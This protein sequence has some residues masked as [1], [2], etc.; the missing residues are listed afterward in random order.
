MGCRRRGSGGSLEAVDAVTAIGLTCLSVL[1]PFYSPSNLPILALA[2]ILPTA[3]V[4]VDKTLRL[5]H[6]GLTRRKV[7]LGQGLRRAKPRPP[8]AS[9]SGVSYRLPP[10]LCLINTSFPMLPPHCSL[11]LQSNFHLSSHFQ[12]PT[13]THSNMNPFWLRYSL[14]SPRHP[15]INTSGSF[16]AGIAE[17][18]SQATSQAASTSAATTNP[19]ASN[20]AYVSSFSS[21]L[22]SSI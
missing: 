1:F 22:C 5:P 14:S 7:G 19:I 8:S 10:S 4:S 18:L 13:P 3:F 12:L 2:A 16:Q 17:G 6:G 15:W 21:R 20:I 9:L 11:L